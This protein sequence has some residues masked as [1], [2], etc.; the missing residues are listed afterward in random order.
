[1]EMLPINKYSR[2]GVRRISTDAIIVHFTGGPG[3][4]AE[5]V[6][7]FLEKRTSFGG[8]TYLVDDDGVLQLANESEMTPHVGGQM[9]PLFTKKFGKQRMYNGYSIQNWR[10]IGGSFCHPD[11]TGKPTDSTYNHLIGLLAQLCLTYNKGPDSL[12]RHYDV[13]GKDCPAYYVKNIVMWERLKKD[14]FEILVLK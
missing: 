3:Q 10:T 5:Q 12:Y 11:S 8:Y 7:S 1:M 4:N 6:R 9:T 2:P 13:T 14:V